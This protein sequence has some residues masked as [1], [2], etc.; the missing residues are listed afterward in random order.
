MYSALWGGDL[1][2]FVEQSNLYRLF[3]NIAFFS[4][5]LGDP[6]VLTAIKQ[7]PQG[8]HTAYRYNRSYP[9]KPGNTEFA[10]GFNA[11][12]KHEPTNW[13]W[14]NLV[15]CGFIG[16]AL[17]RTNGRTEAAALAAEVQGMKITSPLA[18]EEVITMRDTDH[19]IIGYPIAWG[20]TIPKAPYVQDY[21]PVEWA[22]VLELE[23]QWKRN[24]GYA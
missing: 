5:S 21:A 18:V 3:S 13:A 15:A 6:P 10:E 12:A 7:L 16:E 14:Q 19:T 9:E 11:L 20:R 4:S 1:V 17:K 2:S 24:K 22:K 8:L 23:S